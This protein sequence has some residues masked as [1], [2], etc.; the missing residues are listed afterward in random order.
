MCDPQGN[1]C[2]L[3]AQLTLGLRPDNG[4]NA[5]KSGHRSHGELFRVACARLAC[6]ELA[7]YTVLVGFEVQNLEWRKS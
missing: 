7:G 1:L 3:A 4:G 6:A 2:A 5:V